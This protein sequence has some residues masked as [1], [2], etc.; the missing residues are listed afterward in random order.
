[1]DSLEYVTS[2]LKSEIFNCTQVAKQTKVSRTTLNKIK[3]GEKVKDYMITALEVFF[4][5]AGE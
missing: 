1:M 4:R 2:K 5:K 3:R